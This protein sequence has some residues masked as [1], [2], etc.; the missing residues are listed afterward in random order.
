VTVVCQGQV[1]LYNVTAQGPENDGTLSVAGLACAI[2]WV[3]EWL[4]GEW[5]LGEPWQVAVGI[6]GVV[7]QR[8]A[9]GERRL[10]AG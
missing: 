6:G 5:D 9:S 3:L 4:L 1:T 7:G 10:R 2:G 8:D